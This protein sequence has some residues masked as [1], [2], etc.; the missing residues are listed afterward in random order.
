MKVTFNPRTQFFAC[1]FLLFL[2]TCFSSNAWSQNRITVKG[3]VKA[4]NGTILSNATVQVVGGSISR[5][6]DSIGAY[7][8][9]VPIGG[10]LEFSYVGY[11]TRSIKVTSPELNV[12]LEENPNYLSDVVV[13]GY[14]RQKLPT[15]TGAIGVISGKDLTQSPVAN[16]TNM[17]VGRTAGVSGIQASGEPGLNNTTIR[18]RGVA[19]LNGQD[20]LIVIDGIQQP[21]EQPYIVLN[22]MDASEIESISVLKDASATAVYGIRGAN[23]VIIVTT[24]RGRLNKP[25]FSFSANQGFT[26]AASLFET[27]GSYQFAQLRNEAVRNA[28]AAG[29][30]AYNYLLFTDDELWK[31]QNNR[32]YTPAEV[33]AMTFLKPEQQAA[34][35]NSPALYYTDNNYYEEVFGG[36]GRQQQYNLNVSGGTSK[37]KYFTSL[38]FFQQ[39]GILNAT[40]YAS[41]NT[42][43][44]Y[45]RYNFRSNFD[46]DVFRNFQLTFNLGGQSAVNRVV[47]SG[48]SSDFA[49]RYQ[50]IIQGIL[51]GSPFAGPGIVDGKLVTGYIGTAGDATNP[52]GNKGGSGSS[53]NASLYTGGTR[54]VYSTTLTSAVTLK[55]KMGYLTNGL[56]SHVT[57]AYDDSYAKGFVRT[58]SVPT[59]QAMRDPANPLNILFIG[60]QVNSTYTAD[61]QGNSSW[62]KLYVEAGANYNRSFGDHNVSGLFL[63]NAQ[64]YTAA[65]NDGNAQ[66]FNTPSGLMGLVGRATYNFKERY[67]A[68]FNMGL[69]GT[70]NF[71]T[72]RRFGYFPAVSGGWILSNESFWPENKWITWAKFRGSYGEVGNDQIGGRRYLY[73]PN[74]WSTSSSGYWFGN[75]N[76]SSNNPSFSG[77]SESALGNPEVTWERA[78][79]TNLSM[80]M[81]FVK[82]KLTFTGSWFQ[83]KR[84]D[85]LV[86]SG[87][88]PATYGVSQ[89]QTPPLNLGRVS[90]K[91][92]EI[93][94]GWTDEIGAVSYFVKGNYSFA[95]NKIEYRAEAPYPYPWMNE[96]GYAIGQYK[97][98]LTDGFYN[99]VEELNNRPYNKY[100]ANARL[101]D[102]KYVDVNGD[103][104]I[105]DQ[106]RVPIGYSNLPQVAYN[107]TIGFSY[108]GF[109]VNALFIGTAKGSF[110][111]SG[112]VLSTPFAKNVGAVMQYMYDGRWT[113]EKYAAGQAA[114]YPA[115]SFSGGQA[116]NT[117]SN[118]WLKPND[119]KRLKNLE[120]GYTF[121]PGTSF[122]KRASIQGIRLYANGNNL[123]TWDYDVQEGIDPE[124]ADTGKNSMGYLFPLTRTF[125][126]GVSVQF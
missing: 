106:D 66:T 34:L 105:D 46:I 17:L 120:I 9:L 87:I 98:L 58:N 40:N 52:L 48:G 80:E 64:R 102:L 18:I 78:Q 3:T 7:S 51:E 15:V 121:Q 101:G 32:D 72:G 12:I 107:L 61:N 28:Q 119:F 54:T 109:D 89:S 92:F 23:G 73:L 122:M 38:G 11:F 114:T 124:Q 49:N 115:I 26:K 31:F 6:T 30:Q 84:N 13:V 25:R 42:N 14:G 43:P 117:M 21:A 71:A 116:N 104:F 68:E 44:N 5:T 62:R 59:Y 56:E 50:A 90:N 2:L 100:S 111:Q 39:D 47:G 69:N 20:P 19:T 110:P 83:E 65:N 70:E 125:N 33:D 60:G 67:M 24:K 118:F 37:V 75:S 123:L 74:T 57:V 41:A 4:Q 108:K 96:T 27:V 86:T 36:T 93:E 79:K 53:P 112:Y 91:G 103:G 95:R 81:R 55:H 88:V 45:K 97:G 99:T 8:I 35:K 113:P 126:F 1:S 10:A 22:A 94:L 29:D 77:A 85:I 63:A 82:D 76:G 16:I